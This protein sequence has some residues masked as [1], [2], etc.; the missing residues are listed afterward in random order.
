MTQVQRQQNVHT[1]E[2]LLR[3][4]RL[5]WYQ[6]L[7]WV[8]IKSVKKKSQRVEWRVVRASCH[9]QLHKCKVCKCTSK[10][11]QCWHQS[12]IL[13]TI[14]FTSSWTVD[15]VLGFPH[16]CVNHRVTVQWTVFAMC[17]V[18]KFALHKQKYS[19]LVSMQ[20]AM[21]RFIRNAHCAALEI[22]QKAVQAMCKQ[23]ASNVQ[24][25]C[26]QCWRLCRRRRP[27]GL[28]KVLLHPQCGSWNFYDFSKK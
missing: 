17:N 9:V 10:P 11:V 20:N 19:L 28:S 27:S 7:S 6:E 21:V 3:M 2:N 5:S 12:N 26:K 24:A 18:R 23:C 13:C 15:T 22:L 25:M 16:H 4:I 14:Y 1:V 8:C